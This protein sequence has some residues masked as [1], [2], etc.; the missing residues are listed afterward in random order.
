[1]KLEKVI[2]QRK[3]K[4]LSQ[5]DVAE[6]MFLTQSQYSRRENGTIQV[7]YEEWLKLSKILE[8]RVE[9]IFE[10]KFL[11]INEKHTFLIICEEE[12]LEK[13]SFKFNET[14][15]FH[16]KIIERLERENF[17]LKQKLKKFES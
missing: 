6:K 12:E 5:T 14:K 17:N 8:V 15:F 7:V 2:T 10:S 3:L 1:M 16:L 4:G 11:F 9:E 13:N